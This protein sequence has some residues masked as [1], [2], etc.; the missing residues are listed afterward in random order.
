MQVGRTGGVGGVLE[1]EVGRFCAVP[2][3]QGRVEACFTALSCVGAGKGLNEVSE[4]VHTNGAQVNGRQ[5][6]SRGW[7]GNR[8]QGARGGFEARLGCCDVWTD[9]GGV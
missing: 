2:Q 6:Q 3:V 9:M 1:L 8:K 7:V 4:Q 5:V